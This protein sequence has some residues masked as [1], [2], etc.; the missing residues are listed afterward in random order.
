MGIKKL[1]S[2]LAATI[3]IKA[4]GAADKLVEQNPEQF[5]ELAIKNEKLLIEKNETK[6]AEINV[7]K[8]SL[9][10]D[11]K[12]Y[13]ETLKKISVGIRRASMD[14]D[15]ESVL[16]GNEKFKEV[17]AEH[18]EAKNNLKEIEVAYDEVFNLIIEQK[19]NVK[20]ME[21][22]KKSIISRLRSAQTKE[23]VMKITGSITTDGGS[24]SSFAKAR[25][26]LNKK[27]NSINSLD[28]TKKAL[29]AGSTGKKS[30]YFDF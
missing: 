13:V 21:S 30:K 17:E 28:A 4:D 20:K 11:V 24:A 16:I 2:N 25:E 6:L 27:T 3:G 1:L 8:N 5:L 9:S 19:K 15:N 26:V 12:D 18:D 29:S 10:T 14:G 23:D 7:L 22:E